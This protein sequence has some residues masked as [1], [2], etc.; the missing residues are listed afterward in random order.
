MT[1]S[2]FLRKY[3]DYGT[4]RKRVIADFSQTNNPYSNDYPYE[5]LWEGKYTDLKRLKGLI[6][7]VDFD[8]QITE[9]GCK[10]QGRSIECNKSKCCCSDCSKKMGY[11]ELISKKDLSLYIKKFS[12][13]TGF[14]RK[15]K[16]CILPH[17]YRS[18]TCLT[19]HCN[20]SFE[21]VDLRFF[22]SM[23]VFDR[24]LQKA[25]NYLLRELFNVK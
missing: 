4:D 8:C 25:Q 7:F 2:E 11:L 10:G 18:N 24:M 14:W 3:R 9:K 12:V 6:E 19:Y 17:S 15:G 21:G 5:K 16:G 20:R 22:H 13:K 1:K 23:S